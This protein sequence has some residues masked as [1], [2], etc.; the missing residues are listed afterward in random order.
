MA[1]YT[2]L[3]NQVSPSCLPSRMHPSVGSQAAADRPSLPVIRASVLVWTEIN[4]KRLATAA[5]FPSIQSAPVMEVSKVVTGVKRS[6]NAPKADPDK[7]KKA[8]GP[9]EPAPR[10]PG[11]VDAATKTNRVRRNNRRRNVRTSK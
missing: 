11:A 6:R 10:P 8:A 1:R 3:A 2:A 7:C 9:R 4:V 5:Q